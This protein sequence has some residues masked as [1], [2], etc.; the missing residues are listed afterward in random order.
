MES[1]TALTAQVRAKVG[2]WV[3][4]LRTVGSLA[5][6]GLVVLYLLGLAGLTLLGLVTIIGWIINASL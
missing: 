5:A 2:D 3:R 4:A 6:L 1:V